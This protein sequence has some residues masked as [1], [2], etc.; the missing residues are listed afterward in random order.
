MEAKG[1]TEKYPSLFLQKKFEELSA[2]GAVASAAV[3]DTE[4][5]ESGSAEEEGNGEQ[6]DEGVKTGE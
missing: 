4:M 1:T 2:A 5:A 6:E 3:D